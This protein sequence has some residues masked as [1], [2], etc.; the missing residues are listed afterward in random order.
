ML[1]VRFSDFEKWGCVN[2]G[3]EYC[4]RD[5]VYSTSSAILICGECKTK[6]MVLDDAITISNMGIG[7]KYYDGVVISEKEM[8][9]DHTSYE[10][11]IAI[12]KGDFVYPIVGFHP[13]EGILT[14]E[15]HVPDVR[16]E[17]GVGEF[18]IPRGVGYDLACFVK[19]RE[20]GNRI[21]SMFSDV[22]E[23]HPQDAFHAFLDYREKEPLWIQVKIQ[24]PSQ[25]RALLLEKLI[26]ENNNII[27]LS[28]IEEATTHEIDFSTIWDCDLKHSFD[29]T[30]C[31][32]FLQ[33]SFIN[34][35]SVT[36]TY[37]KELF[38]KSSQ[39][40]NYLDQFEVLGTKLQVDYELAK[41]N[42]SG[43]LQCLMHF[44]SLENDDYSASMFEKRNFDHDYI[45]D[46]RESLSSSVDDALT[47]YVSLKEDSQYYELPHLGLHHAREFFHEFQK[48]STS[49]IDSVPLDEMR[50]MKGF[51]H[52][53]P[54]YS[55]FGLYVQANKNIEDG[56]LDLAFQAFS[57]VARQID[58][59]T[60]SLE[61]LDPNIRAIYHN[62]SDCVSKCQK[63]KTLLK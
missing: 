54:Y 59:N 35:R 11:G 14:H 8:A 50:K 29:H 36:P 23:N 1:A 15:L 19:S 47:S 56:D 6:F 39:N 5:S 55:L 26:K 34:L 21:V 48:I 49:I 44:Q 32:S 51:D 9:D 33:D 61:S 40:V 27:T 18:C 43:A 13:R 63:E 17:D 52:V 60:F 7:K 16:P 2:C 38:D 53:Y 42:T 30:L 3:C 45:N 24:Y 28:I 62:I 25:I 20:S 10:K 41:K 12:E 46:L 31:D 58:S 37:R 57:H 4:Y 22:E